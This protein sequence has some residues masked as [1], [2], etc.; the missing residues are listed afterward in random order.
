MGE[1]E[2]ADDPVRSRLLE[3]AVRVFAREGYAGTKILDIVR[4]AGLSTATVY[5]RFRSKEE[6]LREAVVSRSKSSG[7]AVPEEPRRVADLIARAANLRS[8]PLT[9]DEAVRLEA[10]VTARREPQVAAA[11]ADA[12]RQRRRSVQPL[13]DAAQ[14][15]GTVA[16]GVDPEAVLFLVQT[17]YLGMLLQRAAG[18]RG[19]D[20]TGWEELVARMV[21]SFG[22]TAERIDEK[23]G[24]S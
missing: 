2:L 20:Q 15:D 17:L 10:Y 22:G 6:L 21:E 4:E 9:D 12:R 23:E 18:V 11:L 3:A 14:V 1:P 16:A 13:V 19:P 5:G 24:L 7:H 8:A